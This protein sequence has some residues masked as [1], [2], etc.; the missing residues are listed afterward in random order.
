MNDLNSILIEGR[1]TADPAMNYT[2]KGADLLVCTFSIAINRSYRQDQELKEE[3]SFLDIESR[4][5]L[6]ENCC[7]YLHKGRGVKI[8]GRLRQDRW[9]SAG[10]TRSKIVAVAEHVEFKPEAKTPR[11]GDRPCLTRPMSS[12]V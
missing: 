9:D 10:Q 5:R 7:E 8:V 1:L 2:S 3:T 6:A 4:G 11:S 12:T